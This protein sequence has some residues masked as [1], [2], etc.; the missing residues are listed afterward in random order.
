ME[1]KVSIITITYNC[2]TLIENTLL[3]CINQTYENKELIV[4]DGDSSDNTLRE[5][6]KYQNKIELIVSEPDDGI[7]SAMNKGISN[8]NGDWIIFMNA[9]DSFASSTILTELKDLLDDQNYGV[10]YS[11]HFLSYNNRKRLI[12][13]IPFFKQ[14]RRYRTMGFSHQSCIVRRSL[15]NKFRFNS[16]Y[17]LCADYDM[18]F[19]IYYNEKIKFTKSTIPI[20]IMDDS[21][22]ETVNKYKRHLREEC[23]ICGY[24]D[25]I[26]RK[27]FIE[28]KFWEFRIKR[29]VKK[30]IY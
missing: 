24:Q 2:E 3:S 12:D 14:T 29:I 15:A 30:I 8:A 25:S 20:A 23:D 4:I 9:G 10:I 28:L 27:L 17:K 6:K 18:L 19:K 13:D 11:P 26:R 7:F 1:S 21:G 22:G 16:K 5:I